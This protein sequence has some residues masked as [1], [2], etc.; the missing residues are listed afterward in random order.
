MEL[1]I[2]KGLSLIFKNEQKTFYH[3]FLRVL[4]ITKSISPFYN[5]AEVMEQWLIIIE[6]NNCLHYLHITLISLSIRANW[7]ELPF[8]K[9]MLQ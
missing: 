3:Y 2:S 4:Q 9:N 7:F 6:N 1:I 5:K 8:F